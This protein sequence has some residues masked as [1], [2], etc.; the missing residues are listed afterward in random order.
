MGLLLSL[1]A[2]P[3]ARH[4]QAQGVPAGTQIRSWATGSFVLNSVPFTLF[5]DTAEVIVAQVGGADLEPPRVTGGAIGTQ[6][7]L[8]QVLT[9]VGN[10]T[11]SFAVAATSARGWAI[12]IYR[13]LNEDGLINGA[14]APLAGP[15]PLG[16]AGHTGL[17]AQVTVPN[18][19][20]LAGRSDTVRVTATSFF[21]AAVRDSLAHRIDIPSTPLTVSVSK[22]ADRAN[23]LPGDPIT[24]T[25]SYSADRQWRY[26]Q[27]FHPGQRAGGNRV[28]PGD[29]SLER[30]PPDR[31]G[32]G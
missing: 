7:V 22:A 24:Y 25:L 16:Y 20:T 32:R 31:R 9:N 26:H 3:G 12:T 1:L 11:D 21:D 2:G 23:A 4:A 17:I 27:L 30:R 29:T 8:P 18:D 10:G 19:P 5:S 14:D 28:P 6:V 13:D 15:V